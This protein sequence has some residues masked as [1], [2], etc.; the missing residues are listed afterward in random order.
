LQT[1]LT[2][3]FTIIHTQKKIL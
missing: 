2:K 1:D 3:T